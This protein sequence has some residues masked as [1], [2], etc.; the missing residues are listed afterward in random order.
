M[1]QCTPLIAYKERHHQ[2]YRM[3]LGKHSS[4]DAIKAT[5]REK[6]L[7]Q[8]E[9]RDPRPQQPVWQISPSLTEDVEEGEVGDMGTPPGDVVVE[10]EEEEAGPSA[11]APPEDV[12]EGEVEEIG[13]MCAPPECL[14]PLIN[15]D[16]EKAENY[17]KECLSPR[18]NGDLKEAENYDKDCS[19]P[20]TNGDPENNANY[21]KQGRWKKLRSIKV[22]LIP[23][24]VIVAM[25][26]LTIIVIAAVPRREET[27]TTGKEKLIS[28]CAECMDD[29]MYYKGK[30]YYFSKEQ[31]TWK[32]SQNFCQLQNSSLVI[33]DSEKE[34]RVLNDHR[35][36]G[37]HWIGLSRVENVWVW[38]NNTPYSETIFNITRLDL[39]PGHSEHVFLNHE[40]VISGSGEDQNKWICYKK[41]D[42][43]E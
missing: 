36:K 40:G 4:K 7:R 2:A 20:I 14:S 43:L 6:R 41:L 10:G 19:I 5:E 30:C 32:N 34:L 23:V 25:L 39:P 33:I 28:K 16:I 21:I 13:D 3:G 9:P 29:W 17:D 1:L 26:I 27:P 31:D 38:T 22:P 11:S 15:G 12:Y 18:T 42:L 35:G 8:P 37:N 24:L